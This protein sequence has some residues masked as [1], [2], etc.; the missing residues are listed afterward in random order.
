MPEVPLEQ[1]KRAHSDVPVDEVFLRR[2][3]P[4]AFAEQPVSDLNLRILFTAGAW[5]ASSYNEQPWR[6]VLG[7]KGDEPWK[8]IF[9]HLTTPN[10]SWAKMAPVLYAGFA[11]KTFARDGKP[12]PAAVHDL[13]AASANIAL[14]ATR[15]GLHTHGM[16]GFDKPGLH[17]ALGAPED[18][19]PVACWALGYLGDAE[20][21]PETYREME[22]QPR[23]RKPL[24]QFVFASWSSAAL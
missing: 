13:G 5:A 9:T 18:Y 19:E 3:S 21:L 11:K 2:W 14:Q 24:D 6:F 17:A 4:R 1:I 16:V 10:Q 7:R 20:G 15:L 22:R 8:H 12:N 23:Q